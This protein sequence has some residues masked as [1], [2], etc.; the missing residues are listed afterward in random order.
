METLF[1]SG[2]PGWAATSHLLVA[3]WIWL[4]VQG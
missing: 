2:M 4:G 3:P 1:V